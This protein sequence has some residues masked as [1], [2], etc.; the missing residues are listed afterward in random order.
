M[1]KFI[2]LTG[3]RF[4]KLIVTGVA[5]VK[6]ANGTVYDVICDCGTIKRVLGKNL[7]RGVT[8]ACGYCRSRDIVGLT[9]G[10]WKCLSV[11]ITRQGKTTCN[12]V[13][14]CGYERQFTKSY[15]VSKKTKTC[16]KCSNRAKALRAYSVPGR[17][18]MRTCAL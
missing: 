13:C 5:D 14:E 15:L 9:F 18:S 6:Y 8:T 11:E 1:G 16:I 10:S 2:D 3:Q 17:Q 7:S 12:C 4:G